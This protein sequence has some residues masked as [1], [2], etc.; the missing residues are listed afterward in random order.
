[1]K[2]IIAAAGTGGHINPGIAIANK[3]KEEEPNSKIIFIG[4]KRGIEKDLVPRAG[5]ELKTIESYG[6]SKKI[7]FDNIKKI[8][9]TLGSIR[10]VKKI[11]KEF[12]PDIVIGTGGYICISVCGAAKGLKVPFI[13]HESNVL[14]GKATKIL[15]PDAEK[16]LVGFKEAEEKLPNAKNVV[17]TG[18]PTKG[19]DLHY[20]IETKELKKQEIGF[21]AKK[22]L[23][24]VFG[25]SQGSKSI[26][27]AII[28]IIINRLKHKNE[29][30]NSQIK[31]HEN[32][33]NY[34]II[35][36]TGPTQYGEVKQELNKEE[37]N[38]E[39]LPGIKIEPYIYNMGEIMNVA[40]LIVCRSGAMTVTELEKIGKA[41]ILIPVPYAAEN[42]QE[43]NARALE[44]EGAARVI[45][46]RELKFG[47]LNDMINELVSEPKK[48]KEMSKKSKSLSINNVEDRIYTEI[49][50]VLN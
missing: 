6:F 7:T 38:I 31:N 39:N 32:Y 13:I 40:D 1:M 41:S 17:V 11:I 25:G 48:L 37:L 26:N 33:N 15:S 2:V 23:V 16:I 46:D 47:G 28:D 43:Y 35:W 36:A 22:P 19:E 30:T 3:I 42:H 45:L 27:G 44:N 10:K 50:Q 12:N 20:D 5:Y 18:T 24:L 4:T 9:K 8:L 21:D 34:Q 29:E 49:K 14:P